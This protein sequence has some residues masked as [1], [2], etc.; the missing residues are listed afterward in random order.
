M[1]GYHPGQTLYET[2]LAGPADI[3]GRRMEGSRDP[4][5]GRKADL[6]H[7]C[8]RDFPDNIRAVSLCPPQEDRSCNPT[9]P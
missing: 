1:R 6:V 4:A 9:A 8:P 2:P 7:W 3:E 5:E